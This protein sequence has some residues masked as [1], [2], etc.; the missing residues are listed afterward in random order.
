[1]HKFRNYLFANPYSI[2][3]PLNLYL[4]HP[5]IKRN[6]EVCVGFVSKVHRK[7]LIINFELFLLSV[8]KCKSFIINRS[9]WISILYLSV[10][11]N[12]QSELLDQ[13]SILQSI[14]IKE[15]K[16]C[17]FLSLKSE[18]FFWGWK[19]HFLSKLHIFVRVSV[20][21]MSLN[22]QSSIF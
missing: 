21:H 7:G 8:S 14:W 19:C 18:E 2:Q 12:Q 20:W 9:N 11:V 22:K 6:S 15:T 10:I 1:M 13:K 16:A 5:K 3:E 4:V 17:T